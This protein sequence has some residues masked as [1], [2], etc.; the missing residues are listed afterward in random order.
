MYLQNFDFKVLLFNN[1]VILYLIWRS[2]LNW[3][4]SKLLIQSI[5]LDSKSLLCSFFFSAFS[6]GSEKMCF[7]ILWPISY[8]SSRKFPL[9]AENRIHGNFLPKVWSVK[10]NSI[11]VHVFQGLSYFNKRSFHPWFAL[12]PIIIYCPWYYINAIVLWLLNSNLEITC[13]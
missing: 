11:N 8:H 1:F 12:H 6:D 7:D 3:Y 10:C 9:S 4:F 5:L 2:C 13:N